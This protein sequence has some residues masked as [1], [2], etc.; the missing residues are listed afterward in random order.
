[1]CLFWYK[2]YQNPKL[3]W[4]KPKGLPKVE[5]PSFQNASWNLDAS[6]RFVCQQWLLPR[7]NSHLFTSITP[8]TLEHFSKG[9]LLNHSTVV[10]ILQNVSRV[11]GQQFFLLSNYSLAKSCQT[12]LH[13]TTMLQNSA[14]DSGEIAV[15]WIALKMKLD[16]DQC[17]SYDQW[18]AFNPT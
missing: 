11:K 8:F 4:S 9:P 13:F 7:I 16:K 18:W 5:M 17:C 12:L 2:K 15:V 3:F 1:M 6:F 10:Q 14:R